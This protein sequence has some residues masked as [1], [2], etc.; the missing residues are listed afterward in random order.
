MEPGAHSQK[1]VDRPWDRHA[2]NISVTV[3]DKILLSFPGWSE[4]HL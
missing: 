3:P 2:L 1:T 4:Y